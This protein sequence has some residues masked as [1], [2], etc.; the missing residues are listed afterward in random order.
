[1]YE[2]PE[3][4]EN[5]FERGFAP[6]EVEAQDLPFSDTVSPLCYG[7]TILLVAIVGAY[8]I[9]GTSGTRHTMSYRWMISR[10]SPLRAG[11]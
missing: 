9:A 4:P 10:E 8:L 5:D 1:M 6:P 3:V 2:D 7:G 11:S